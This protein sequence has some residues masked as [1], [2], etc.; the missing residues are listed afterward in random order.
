MES[1]DLND[2]NDIESLRR[3]FII[4]KNELRMMIKRGIDTSTYTITEYPNSNEIP[5]PNIIQIL[6]PSVTFEV[7]KQMVEESGTFN[8][9]AFF[10][11][12][13]LH[14]NKIIQV[15]Y[16]LS[17]DKVQKEVFD[18]QVRPYLPH[19]IKHFILISENELG[20][21]IKTSIKDTLDGILWE[22]FLDK[23]LLCDVSQ[24]CFAPIKYVYIPPEDASKYAETEQI[25]ENNLPRAF[26]S[27]VQSKIRG[28]LHL[29]IA[30]MVV[31]G[32]FHD[33]NGFYRQIRKQNMPVKAK[34]K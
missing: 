25:E 26:T 23:M 31:C 20:S 4:K 29:G 27:D 32:V 22:E 9:R 18:K 5:Y 21:T 1:F 2:K 19:G 10:S 16:L 13:Y 14:N 12:R 30:E 3:L 11:C 24:H 15:V 34:N 33:K 8:K 17:K 6:D 7:F 28:A